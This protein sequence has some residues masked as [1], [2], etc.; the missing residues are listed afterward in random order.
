MAATLWTP[1]AGEPR[2][3]PRAGN[4][5]TRCEGAATA[6]VRVDV[7]SPASTSAAASEEGGCGSESG[8]ATPKAAAVACSS[9]PS[10]HA[11][12]PRASR[13]VDRLHRA[14][15]SRCERRERGAGGWLRLAGRDPTCCHATQLPVHTA[16]RAHATL[17]A[18][19]AWHCWWL[20]AR[21]RTPL[22]L[23]Q[24]RTRVFFCL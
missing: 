15:C 16:L 2:G 6:P 11:A 7:P 23:R 9:P 10:A 20:V 19:L 4:P 14:G 8:G 24:L 5:Q 1:P 22:R 18:R 3:E 12:A 13:C 17:R 21:H